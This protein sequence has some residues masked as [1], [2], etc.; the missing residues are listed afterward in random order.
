[1]LRHRFDVG[2]MLHVYQLNV[3]NPALAQH[4]NSSNAKDFLCRTTVQS[5]NGFSL[6]PTSDNES[7]ML[8]HVCF[9][10]YCVKID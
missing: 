1:M 10:S 4:E 2:T 3:K 7:F 5:G 8:Q 9:E 6:V